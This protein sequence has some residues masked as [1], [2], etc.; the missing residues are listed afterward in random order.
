[1][2]SGSKKLYKREDT[3]SKGNRAQATEKEQEFDRGELTALL[4]N[5][6]RQTREKL[7]F[8]CERRPNSSNMDLLEE[9][10][11]DETYVP[12]YSAI[13]TSALFLV[14]V[15]SNILKGGGNFASPFNITCGSLSYWEVIVAILLTICIVALYARG[16]LLC[17]ASIKR[18]AGYPQI[19]GDI[20]WEER[21]TLVYPATSSTLA[22]CVAGLGGG[23]VEGPLMISMG[24]HPSVA[25]ATSAVMILFTSFTATTSF[26]VYGLYG[27]QHNYAILCV[28]LGFFATWMGQLIMERLVETYERQSY[29]IFA[30][31]TVV[32]ISCI[33][34]TVESF[35][36]LTQNGGEQAQYRKGAALCNPGAIKKRKISRYNK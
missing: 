35:L 8:N 23:I 19:D 14:I 25:S 31:G 27:L 4:V 28:T 6:M 29:I 17:K 7:L 11:D 24:I 5:S 2:V 34:M 13:T 26:A 1:M 12:R 18:E 10:L 15:A 21:T 22:G 32:A 36:S 9:I 20:Q 16:Y 3:L 33:L 30:I